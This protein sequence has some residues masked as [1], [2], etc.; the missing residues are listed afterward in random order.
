M[1]PHRVHILSCVAT[2][3]QLSTNSSFHVS[4]RSIAF[5]GNASGDSAAIGGGQVLGCAHAIPSSFMA[6]TLADPAPFAQRPPLLGASI[7]S[8]AAAR[9]GEAREGAD[10]A[11][12]PSALRLPRPAAG[13]SWRGS[14]GDVNGAG[15]RGREGPR[16]VGRGVTLPTLRSPA[17]RASFGASTGA[18]MRV[19]EGRVAPR[20]AVTMGGGAL[21]VMLG[22][23][24]AMD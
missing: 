1:P 7:D 12:A 14:G 10:P 17:K 24:L 15:R 5:E 3:R 11:A 22:R 21:P 2:P 18:A 16:D 19:G 13:A 20:R 8:A 4:A 9:P 23:W 6:R